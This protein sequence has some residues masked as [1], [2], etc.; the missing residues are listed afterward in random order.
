MGYLRQ[1]YLDKYICPR[2]IDPVTK[3]NIESQLRYS[4]VH[5]LG[6]RKLQSF[7]P[8]DMQHLQ[9]YVRKQYSGRTAQVYMV[10]CK[11]MIR[12]AVIWNYLDKDITLG[13]DPIR[14]VRHKP[15]ILEPQTVL[16]IM[17]HP[18]VPLRDRCMIGLGGFAGL[19]CSEIC[20]L[21]KEKINFKDRTI[22]IDLQCRRGVIKPPKNKLPRYVPI[23]PDLAPILKTWY[24]QAPPGPWLFSNRQGQPL[25][26]S[27]YAQYCFKKILYQLELPT[28]YFHALRHGFNKML[29]DHGVPLRETMQ[30]MGHQSPEMTLK[31]YDRASIKRIVQVIDT[32]FLSQEISRK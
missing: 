3:D 4:I 24:L 16:W 10:A 5:E 31:T 30:I 7:T 13:L 15:P 12:R 26:S 8:I 19:R 18:Q 17:H 1:L 20:G 29:Q 28:I 32:C 11:R 25:N 21:Q 22:L 23:L 14:F 27:S 9:K 6:D 2:S